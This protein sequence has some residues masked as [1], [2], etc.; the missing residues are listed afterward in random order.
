MDYLCELPNDVA[1]RRAL[2][3]LPP[4]LNSTYERLLSRVNQR[5]PETQELVRR[6]LRWIALAPGMKI[7][8]LCEA[9]SVDLGSTKRDCQAIPNE[10]DIL[11]WCSSLVRKSADGNHLELAH[12]TVKEFLQQIDPNR[13]NLIGAFRIDSKADQV[14]H[15]KTCLTY[16][17]YEDF[18]DSTPFS[19]QSVEHRFQEYPFRYEAVVHIFWVDGVRNYQDEDEIFSLLQKLLNP[20]K[21]NTLIS[22]THDLTYLHIRYN[23]P[24]PDFE[25]SL[26]FLHSGIAETSALHWAAILG[27]AKVCS[28]LI[29]NGC[30]VNRDSVFGTPLHCAL[31]TWD[32][33]SM[34]LTNIFYPYPSFNSLHD[35]PDLLI[36]AGADTKCYHG[37]GNRNLSFLY[38]AL[39]ASYYKPVIQLLDNGELLDDHCL[40][41]LERALD[42]GS[43]LGE[44]REMLNRT[45]LINVQPDHYGR[46]IQMNDKVNAVRATHLTESISSLPFPKKH[47]EQ[48]LRTAADLGQV[49]IAKC[50]LED[51]KLDL[52][53]ADESTG[54]TALHQAAKTDQLEVLQM[55][56][57]HG[58]DWSR[59]DGQGRTVLHYAAQG[60]ELCCLKFL[61][62]QYKRTKFR[63]LEG[64]KVRQLAAQE[65]KMQ[66]LSTLPSMPGN[67]TSISLKSKDG[68]TPLLYASTNKSEEA[69]RLLI[70]A[71]SNLTDTAADGS[72]ALHY[73]AS[74]GSVEVVRFIFGHNT[75]PAVITHDGSSAIHC[76]IEKN[77]ENLT[78]IL[79]ILVKSGV[80]PS[81]P[82]K[83][84]CTPLGTIVKIIKEKSLC[85]KQLKCLFNA[86][87]ALL[88][89]LLD[90]SETAS[91]IKQGSELIYLAC[92]IDFDGAHETI[93]ALLGLGL[94]CNIRFDGGRTALMAA[95]EH[96]RV[97][98]LSTL[99]LHRADLC[100]DTSGLTAIHYACLND[101]ECILVR[102]RGTIIDWNSKATFIRSGKQISNVTALHI[103]A[104]KATSR[105][106]RYLLNEDLMS[107][108]N[109]R[110]SAGETPMWGAV[111]TRSP[112]NVSL[113]LSN[114]V[115][116]SC[117]D[118]FGN[119]AIHLAAEWGYEDIISEFIGNGSDM[120][121]PNNLGLP[122]EL[123]AR[124]Y[125][126]P[127][128]AN[129][130][131]NYVNEQNAHHH[132]LL[133]TFCELSNSIQMLV[134]TIRDHRRATAHRN[135]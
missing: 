106:L 27:L 42:N 105:A 115:D 1:R 5:P 10:E 24:G 38:I 82:R 13:D 20:S 3:S 67:L 98:I 99:L 92:S 97:T 12:F 6:A 93:S 78:E 26:D 83:D 104:E 50:L 119:T 51:H 75:D 127:C 85:P 9:V 94:D 110:T 65:G 90:Q 79:Q 37:A 128:L 39:T 73:A 116:T 30:D 33:I 107:D 14:I 34:S 23:N 52:N 11:R 16:L 88:S 87:L 54:L 113:L 49:E 69:M 117:A 61:L 60:K 122:P 129:I 36:E 35:V 31:L 25:T 44:I 123:V 4:D 58:A 130:I 95:A 134:H 17:N 81:R 112:Q 77:N 15:A 132:S 53:A 96:G 100:A 121:L 57:D 133:L 63:D 48:I 2:N 89:L 64:M 126:H 28:W 114:S 68:R 56:I 131:M 40:G 41:R 62:C 45:S 74:S 101:H 29:Q 91:R 55:L 72:S 80:D 109:A 46:L 86:S 19:R 47:Y 111:L 21:P 22:W 8:A 70:D 43:H 76:A 32:A 7:E 103:A 84:G 135:H 18:N 108:I 118:S 125:N 102:L 120:G 59:L 71:G 66:A 124:K